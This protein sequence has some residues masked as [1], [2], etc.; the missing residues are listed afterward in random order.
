AEI[1]KDEA[2]AGGE[3]PASAVHAPALGGGSNGQGG[4]A[5]EGSLRPGELDPSPSGVERRLGQPAPRGG[6]PWPVPWPA[7]GGRA[8]A[9]ARCRADSKDLRRLAVEVDVDRN[10][11]RARVARP[12]AQPR[13]GDEEVEQP[14]GAIPRPMDEH[15][16]ARAGPGE[17]ALRD[18]RGERGRD[19]RV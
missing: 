2:V 4:D 13:D 18:P 3:R 10:H 16:A 1:A 19:A 17:G 8:R 14:V 9:G 11:L 15:E 6:A 5:M 7:A 12:A